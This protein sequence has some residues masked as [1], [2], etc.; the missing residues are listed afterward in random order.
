MGKTA[1]MPVVCLPR[2]LAADL[3][4]AMPNKVARLT[5]K[6]ELP[7]KSHMSGYPTYQD[8]ATCGTKKHVSSGMP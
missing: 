4:R 2:S 7:A 5:G 3:A 8:L 6:V 1:K